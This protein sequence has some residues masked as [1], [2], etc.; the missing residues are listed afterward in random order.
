[1]KN[2][3]KNYRIP[4]IVTALALGAMAYWAWQT[5]HGIREYSQERRLQYATGLFEAIQGTI[6]AMTGNTQV[7]RIQIEKVLANF[8][9]NSPVGF[10]IVDQTGRRLLQGGAFLENHTLPEAEG[11]LLVGDRFLYWRKVRLEVPGDD[12]SHQNHQA[13]GV[14]LPTLERGEQ[15]MILE[16]DVHLDSLRYSRAIGGLSITFA[17]AFLCLM[18]SLIAWIMAIRSQVLKEQLKVERAR[19]AHLEELGLAAAGLAHET[20]NPL[21]IILGI[22]QQM[23]NNPEQTELNRQRLEHLMDE[24]D[25]ASARLGNFL[26]FAR[27]RQLKAAA[28]EAQTLMAKVTRVMQSEFDAVGVK[29]TMG[30]PPYTILADAEL[31]EQI[32]VNLLLNSLHASSPGSLVT[33]SMHSRGKQGVI[34]VEDQGTGIPPELLPDI[35]KPYV[36][37]NPDGHGLGLAIVKRFVEAHGW[38]IDI[39]SRPDQGTLVTISEIKISATEE[40]NP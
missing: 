19:R 7:S 29:L 3:L 34:K 30:C 31:L 24:V 40:A 26:T 11:E 2:I 23:A 33:M 25:K 27:Q 37:G 39:D 5:W 10:V 14:V 35:F 17:A 32:L 16:T 18:A 20:K 12:F 22:S 36:A 1:M 9:S 38:A 21:G 6:R 28:L 4:I 15:I 13:A 8:I